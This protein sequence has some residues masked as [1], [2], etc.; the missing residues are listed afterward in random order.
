MSNLTILN[1]D[2]KIRDG[3][4]SLNDLHKASGG[5]EHHRPSKFIRTEQTQSLITEIETENSQSPNMGFQEKAIKTIKGGK[6]AGTYGC[7]ELVYAYA[8]WIS[9]KFSLLVIRTFDKL[10]NNVG[11]AHPKLESPYIDDEQLQHIKTGVGKIVKE[12]GKSFPTVYNTLF[13]FVKAPSVR[14]IRKERY[15]LACSFLGINPDFKVKADNIALPQSGYHRYLT[16][17]ENGEVVSQTDITNS[18]VLDKTVAENLIR[19]IEVLATAHQELK[20][21]CGV[22]FGEVAK[23]RLTTPIM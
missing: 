14:Q 22:I 5:A 15:E 21:R 17:I 18:V 1:Q 9:A 23:F 8:M 7:K 19:D 10:A 16:A 13:D 12:T 4:F 2:I 6:Y 11:V 3:L 20:A